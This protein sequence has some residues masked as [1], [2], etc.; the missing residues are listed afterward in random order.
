LL[1]IALDGWRPGR[2]WAGLRATAELLASSGVDPA[3]C[4]WITALADRYGQTTY[5][6][7][8]VAPAL[9]PDDDLDAQ[10]WLL[11]HRCEDAIHHPD[12]DPAPIIA[13]AVRLLTDSDATEPAALRGLPTHGEERRLLGALGRL[14]ARV[15]RVDEA[16]SLCLEPCRATWVRTG[17]GYESSHALAELLLLH[18]AA[19]TLPDAERWIVDLADDPRTSD[20]SLQFARVALGR[21]LVLAGDLPRALRVLDDGEPPLPGGAIPQPGLEAQRLRWI[22]VADPSRRATCRA[23]LDDLAPSPH[24]NRQRWLLDLE[25]N[26]AAPVPPESRARV[27]RVLRLFQGDQP[28]LATLRRHLLD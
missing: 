21:G 15:G 24:V 26:P 25:D 3:T 6:P 23:A 1:T 11:A 14:L 7:A 22:G 20:A 28:A 18:G 12:L 2:P 19:G 10:A 27:E 16:I 8:L 13:A 9:L 5:T 17:K 4:A